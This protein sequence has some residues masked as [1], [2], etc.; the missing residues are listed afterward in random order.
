M[1]PSGVQTLSY[2]KMFQPAARN[3]FFQTNGII[4]FIITFTFSSNNIWTQQKNVDL[5]ECICLNVCG[6]KSKHLSPEFIQLIT[7]H[8]ICIFIETKT[9]KY[10]I[11]NIP[12]GFSYVVKN[13]K[14]FK[15]K[16]GGIVA[17]F[18]SFSMK[19]ANS[20]SISKNASID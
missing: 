14:L 17:H 5:I 18:M 6:I 19:F 1:G 20:F 4:D 2:I 11:L 13:R 16:S 15:H 9:D 3:F 10:D 7:I 12:D 8:D